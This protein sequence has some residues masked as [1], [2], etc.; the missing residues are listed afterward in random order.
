MIFLYVTYAVL[1]EHVSPTYTQP[2]SSLQ[3]EGLTFLFKDALYPIAVQE[4]I[5]CKKWITRG[6]DREQ[7]PDNT[8]LLQSLQLYNIFQKGPAI[9]WYLNDFVLF[10]KYHTTNKCTNCMSFILN[11]FFKT[12]FIAPT[13]FDSISLII[14]REHI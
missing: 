11:H 12:L 3:W 8:H 1:D 10:T 6:T 7:P 14:I 13:C 9:F 2:V 5:E 4:D